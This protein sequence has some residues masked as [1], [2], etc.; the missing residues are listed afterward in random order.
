LSNLCG[1]VPIDRTIHILL[2]ICYSL[3]EAHHKGLVHRD[4]KPQ[5]IMLCYIGD[6][7]DVVKVLDFG[8]V[9]DLQNNNQTDLTQ[10]FEIGG[11]PMYMSPER[12]TAPQTVD[13]RTDIYS[14]GVI[15]YYLLT[16][17]KPFLTGINDEEII[18]QIINESP[19]E[20]RDDKIP[21]ALT[22]I[23]YKCMKKDPEQRPADINELIALFN[24]ID[25]QTW[26]QANAERWWKEK[27]TINKSPLN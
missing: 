23:I 26:T 6:N 17:K 5:N 3:K 13:Y 11:T 4:I 20:I 10:L 16:A 12:L 24:E 2:Q 15:A 14:I 7:Y 8:L 22:E 18:K 1:I 9:K 25:T 27:V 19:Q 21:E